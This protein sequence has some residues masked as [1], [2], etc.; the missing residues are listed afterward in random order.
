MAINYKHCLTTITN[1][2]SIKAIPILASNEQ[3]MS[4]TNTTYDQYNTLLPILKSIQY[5]AIY[6]IIRCK[7]YPSNYYIAKMVL[8]SGQ[9]AISITHYH[10]I[11]V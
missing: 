4:T 7:L 2:S 6:C 11:W 9:P 5:A 3:Y 1:T 8:P 10:M